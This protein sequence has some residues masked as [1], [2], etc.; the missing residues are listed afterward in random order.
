MNTILRSLPL[1]TRHLSD[2]R[3]GI[4]HCFDKKSLT[5]RPLFVAA[6]EKAAEHYAAETSRKR[7]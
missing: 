4:I 6:S 1:A 5:L 2:C 3:S 7:D